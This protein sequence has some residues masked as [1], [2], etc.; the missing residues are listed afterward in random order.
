MSIPISLAAASLLFFSVHSS[1][2]NLK[3]TSYDFLLDIVLLAGSS[4]V[5]I[6]EPWL[7]W[8]T[9]ELMERPYT[10]N[11]A[12]IRT[13]DPASSWTW[14][15]LEPQALLKNS[16]ADPQ[17]LFDPSFYADK[18]SILHSMY[19]ILT[20]TVSTYL[21][22]KTSNEAILHK[23]NSGWVWMCPP[24]PPLPCCGSQ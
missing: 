16:C 14:P 17:P 19:T 7:S 13:S 11:P 8:R 24:L 22:S 15:L 12:S 18:Y 21:Y 2:F 10:S 4:H 6:V 5:V 9:K 3:E 23:P 1:A 20:C